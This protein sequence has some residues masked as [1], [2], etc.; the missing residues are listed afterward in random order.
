MKAIYP[1]TFDPI[2]NGHMDIIARAYSLCDELI[3]AL[4]NNTQKQC[5][6]SASSR[7]EMVRES[8]S[9]YP[10]IKI[11]TF[12]GLLVEAVRDAGANVIIR[13]LRAISDYEMEVQMAIMNRALDNKIDTVFLVASYKWSFISSS[14]IKDIYQFGGDISPFVP[15]PVIERFKKEWNG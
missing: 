9:D 5:T 13:G 12:D 7:L 14:L 3:V 8:L 15:P 10:D 1:G 11:V 6:F 2:T 4:G